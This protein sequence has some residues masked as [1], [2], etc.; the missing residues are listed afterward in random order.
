MSSVS[1][2][3]LGKFNTGGSRSGNSW[4]QE[5]TKEI[6]IRPW[7]C[8]F[9]HLHITAGLGLNQPV[10]ADQPLPR[11]SF[12]HTH[13]HAT[14]LILTLLAAWCLLRAQGVQSCYNK[15]ISDHTWDGESY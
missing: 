3:V 12:T 14:P 1:D 11:Y 13:T 5:N 2:K 8:D 9:H 10:F 7:D 4:T 15:F 6:V